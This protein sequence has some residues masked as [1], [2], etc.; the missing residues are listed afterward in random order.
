MIY[1]SYL[2]LP[3]FS[4]T[5]FISDWL[6]ILHAFI[7][8]FSCISEGKQFRIPEEIS[9]KCIKSA[10]SIVNMSYSQAEV[11]T[12]VNILYVLTTCHYTMMPILNFLPI[13]NC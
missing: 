2:C 10:E 6:M 8:A 13:T 11:Y 7:I 4:E 5:T 9:L 1:T 12:S 3:K